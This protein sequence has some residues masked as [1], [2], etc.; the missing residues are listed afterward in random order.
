VAR[1]TVLVYSPRAGR[2]VLGGLRRVRS[3]SR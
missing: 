3:G 2:V 1:V